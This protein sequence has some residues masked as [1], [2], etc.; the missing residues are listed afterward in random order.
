VTRWISVTSVSR[1]ASH[2]RGVRRAQVDQDREQRSYEQRQPAAEAP[3][4]AGIVEEG[5]ERD[6][7]RREHASGQLE[8][9]QELRPLQVHPRLEARVT[10]CIGAGQA[11]GRS[12][13]ADARLESELRDRPLVQP[14]PRPGREERLLGI[15]LED[16]GGGAIARIVK[17]D[18]DPMAIEGIVA[19]VPIMPEGA[20]NAAVLIMPGAAGIDGPDPAGA[21]AVR[22]GQRDLLER[23]DPIRGTQAPD[24]QQRTERVARGVELVEILDV[25]ADPAHLGLIACSLLCTSDV[26]QD[27]E[28]EQEKKR[29]A[30]QIQGSARARE[31]CRWQDRPLDP[32]PSPI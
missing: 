26:R 19:H 2:D 31:F 17:R 25:H 27:R 3:P 14:G 24:P 11:V 15:R 5:E 32:R 18:G 7:R 12:F 28:H 23:R 22:R 21:Q 6:Q 30:D 16:Q 13:F 8:E 10:R 9:G 20:L 29:A 1:L 4:V